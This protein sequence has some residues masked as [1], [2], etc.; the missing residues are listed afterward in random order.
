[1]PSKEKEE[2]EEVEESETMPGSFFIEN[3]R[4]LDRGSRKEFI[5][6]ASSC[7]VDY[8]VIVISHLDVLQTLSIVLGMS[9]ANN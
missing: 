2:V 9:R 8:I 6:D 3:R 5:F 7:K 4:S 1:M